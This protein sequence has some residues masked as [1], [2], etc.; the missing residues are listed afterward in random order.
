[1]CDSYFVPDKHARTTRHQLT[2]IGMQH[3]WTW[4]EPE[5]WTGN[6]RFVFLLPSSHASH[7]M[8]CLPLLAHKAPVVQV[9]GLA[10][11]VPRALRGPFL[12]W[13][14]PWTVCG[15]MESVKRPTKDSSDQFQSKRKAV[16]FNETNITAQP[17]P[18][19]K[20]TE[21]S[22]QTLSC[23][24]W[25]D[26][27]AIYVSLCFWMNEWRVID[28]R[29]TDVPSLQ[30]IFNMWT[31]S[32]DISVQRRHWQLLSVYLWAYRTHPTHDV[33]DVM[34]EGWPHHRGLHSLLFLNSGVGS[35]TSHKNQISVS[36]VRRDLRFFVLIWED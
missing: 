20:S 30:Y 34:C 15:S 25:P 36:A 10:S 27:S 22:T 35:F 17:F 12:K 21:K 7:K 6:R 32:S 23:L 33:N 24:S 18:L 2:N 3:S 9:K 29:T 19:V 16:V 4:E 1:M 11:T 26:V 14:K 13:N 8:L 5:Q 31:V 28:E